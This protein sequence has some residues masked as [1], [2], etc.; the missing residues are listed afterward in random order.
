M[1]VEVIVIV[2]GTIGALYVQTILSRS[3]E[4]GEPSESPRVSSRVFREL[5]TSSSA[6]IGALAPVMSLCV[7]CKW[8]SDRLVRKPDTS[9]LRAFDTVCWF[10]RCTTSCPLDSG[11]VGAD[12]LA[13]FCFSVS[14]ASAIGVGSDVGDVGIELHGLIELLILLS[15]TPT[16][17]ADDGDEY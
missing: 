13:S 14:N 4:H 3:L 17:A 6:S 10:L 9:H 15:D 16:L 7:C 5:L 2:D 11:L 12:V 8:S 1:V